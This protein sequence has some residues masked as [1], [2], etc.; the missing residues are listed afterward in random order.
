MMYSNELRG[1]KP[2]TW[3]LPY[4]V[5]YYMLYNVTTTPIYVHKY[6]VHKKHYNIKSYWVLFNDISNI[7]T[8]Y[9]YTYLEGSK[10]L[11]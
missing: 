5:L 2:N 9:F 7:T 1:C 8:S 11:S 3:V 4:H 10:A 6:Y